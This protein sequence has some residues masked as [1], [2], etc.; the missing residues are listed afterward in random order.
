[1]SRA[2]NVA[3]LG[4]TG[5]V[6]QHMIELLEARKFPVANLFPLASSRSAG[7]TIKFRGEEI[8]VLDADTFDWTQV[9]LGFFSAVGVFHEF[10]RRALPRRDVSLSIILRNSVTKKMC[11]W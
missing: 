1:M 11:H 2:F 5:L 6:G 10:L 3:V 7:S 9:E 4:A 8:E